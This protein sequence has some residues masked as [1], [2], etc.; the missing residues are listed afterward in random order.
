MNSAEPSSRLILVTGGLGYIGSCLTQRLVQQGFR[1]RVIDS[2]LYT[3]GA[4]R[5]QGIEL[6]LADIRNSN[7]ISATLD[8]V[9]SVVHLAAIVGDPACA[10]NPSQAHAVN[11]GATENLLKLS[12]QAGVR[13]LVFA[14]TCS[15]YGAGSGEILNE[16][17][18]LNPVSNYASGKVEAEGAVLAAAGPD[19]ETTVLRFS[20]IFGLAPRLRFDLVANLLTARASRGLPIVIHGGGQWRP[21]LHVQDVAA[22][23]IRV[24]QTE[25]RSSIGLFNVG[26]NAG[27]HR[28]EDLGRIIADVVP[29]SSVFIDPATTDHRTYRV[30]FD[31]FERTFGVMDTMPLQSGIAELHQFLADH[32]EIDIHNPYFDNARFL[33]N[34]GVIA[35]GH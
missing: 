20:T 2:G 14:S 33:A 19:W 12:R 13:K 34:R 18:A 21:F 15:V 32:P 16:D 35:P 17:S 31:R 27:N 29:G 9:D 6:H 24:L 28:L 10:L 1:V 25:D 5:N 7:A 4:V 23:I 8:G 11:V 3:S 26:S 22:A 30:S